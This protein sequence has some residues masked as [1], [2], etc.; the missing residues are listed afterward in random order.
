MSASPLALTSPALIHQVSELTRRAVGAWRARWALPALPVD[1]SAV[2]WHEPGRPQ[3]RGQGRWSESMESVPCALFWPSRVEPLLGATLYPRDASE[4][5][6]HVL[7]GEASLARDSVRHVAAELRRV[8]LAAWRIEVP[9]HEGSAS[10]T[11]SRWHAP[12]R[13]EI[14][15]SDECRVL[16][17]VPG[18]RLCKASPGVA[19]RLAPLDPRAFDALPASAQ[20]VVGKADVAVPDLAALQV[21]DVIVLDSWIKDPLEF[22]VAG[23]SAVLRA[24]LGRVN[25]QRAA[26]LVSSPKS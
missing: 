6:G 17:V 7:S 8:L 9:M 26:Q 25:D 5:P 13:V 4:P 23:S 11:P 14:A 22:H 10:A 3:V 15:L 18:A 1:V 21:G 24:C 12:L 19:R 16:A 20:L 2:A